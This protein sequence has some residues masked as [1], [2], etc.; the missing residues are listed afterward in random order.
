MGFDSNNC[1]PPCYLNT[2]EWRRSMSIFNYY[3]IEIDSEKR[4]FYTSRI[5]DSPQDIIE[6]ALNYGLISDS[7][8]SKCKNARTLSNEEVEQRNNDLYKEWW[9]EKERRADL[10]IS[11]I[12]LPGTIGIQLD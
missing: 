1:Y 8:V 9:K 4:V 3:E 2:K 12:T 7:E 11:M 5:E 10:G 6:H